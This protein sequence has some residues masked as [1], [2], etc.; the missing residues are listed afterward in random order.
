MYDDVTFQVL[1]MQALGRNFEVG[2]FYDARRDKIL[3]SN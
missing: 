3:T 1:K 2:T